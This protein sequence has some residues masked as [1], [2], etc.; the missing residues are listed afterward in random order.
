MKRALTILVF[1]FALSVIALW[2][3][4]ISLRFDVQTE[5]SAELDESFWI[6]SGSTADAESAVADEYFFSPLS[7]SLML[8]GEGYTS[9]YNSDLTYTLYESHKTLLRE[10]FS[11]S[12][13]SE[14]STLLKWRE[15]LQKEDSV[16][17]EYPASL[18]YTFIAEFF[19]RTDGFPK[20]EVCRVKSIILFSDEKNNL[21]ALSNDGEGNIYSYSYDGTEA[22]SLIYDFNSSN[23]AAYTVNKGFTQFEFNMNLSEK[24]KNEHL[25]DEYII[26]SSSPALPSVEVYSPL[27]NALN[28]A[29]SPEQSSVLELLSDDT[30]FSVFDSFEINPNIVGFYNDAR[31]GL[32]FVGQ[33]VSMG[34][35]TDGKIEYSV[36]KSE[37]APIT[38]SSL[39]NSDRASF[40]SAER[41]VA[42]TAFLGRI[43]SY[44]IGGEATPILDKVTYSEKTDEMTFRFSYYY[45]LSEVLLKGRRATVTLTFNSLGLTSAEIDTMTLMK[46]EKE[47]SAGV[48]LDMTIPPYAVP[49]VL[50]GENTF[51]PVYNCTQPETPTLP[52]WMEKGAGA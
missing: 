6:F 8:S 14:R 19:G 27:E 31:A 5:K 32:F 44:I 36:T 2:I 20:G 49:K 1:C 11:S 30:L 34:I 15:A 43:P 29:L 23:L 41:L 26:L 3:S 21:T 7:V 45:E 4:Y 33:D 39:I 48:Y 52:V 22:P 47:T 40:G 9:A 51:A 37:A 25:P 46:T 10:V 24:K 18:P 42:A 28:K 12:Y 17:I 50:R 35:S 38:V 13:I 16:F